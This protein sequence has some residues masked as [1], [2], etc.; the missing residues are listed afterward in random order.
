[1]EMDGDRYLMVE[2]EDAVLRIDRQSGR[3]SSECRE[4]PMAGFAG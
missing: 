2:T 4:S 3:Q 1:M